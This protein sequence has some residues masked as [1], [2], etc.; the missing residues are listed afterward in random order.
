VEK[1]SILFA[2]L[3][4][5]VAVW[6]VI[7]DNNQLRRK[8]SQNSIP[9]WWWTFVES[10]NTVVGCILH[11]FPA[12]NGWCYAGSTGRYPHRDWQ[13]CD[14]RSKHK[15]NRPAHRRRARGKRMVSGA[16]MLERR[17]RCCRGRIC[18][19]SSCPTRST[20][21]VLLLL[22]HS[23]IGHGDLRFLEG[24]QVGSKKK[25][26]PPSDGMKPVLLVPLPTLVCLE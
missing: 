9:G 16:S 6:K 4:V 26:C 19:H 3:S 13:A 20:Q 7:G 11:S 18:G 14:R 10:P 17:F 23:S 22:P 12:R 5:S 1:T 21:Q 15:L 2:S 24:V 25:C 8:G